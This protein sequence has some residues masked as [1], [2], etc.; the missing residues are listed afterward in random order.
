M[1][2]YEKQEIELLPESD[3]IQL[4]ESSQQ[5]IDSTAYK[6]DSSY[7][8][9]VRPLPL[10]D[11]EVRGY[12]RQDSIAAIPPAP[13]EDDDEPQD[14]ISLLVNEDGF[15]ANVK[16]RD[17]FS[18]LHLITGG[19]YDL[20]EHVFLQLKGPLQSVNYN[21]VDGFHGGYEI[22]LGNKANQKIN[23]EAGPLIRYNIA[24]E[25]FNYEGKLRLF[26]KGWNLQLNGG[27]QPR[28]FN[29]DFPLSP[30]SNSAYTLI[31]N[32]NYLKEYEQTFFKAEYN[33]KIAGGFGVD[34]G[35]EYAER[36]RCQPQSQ[37]S[38]KCCVIT[39]NFRT[40]NEMLRII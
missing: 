4:T 24:R 18:L 5:Y 19:R 17:K 26:G 2:E 13:G 3:T 15:A 28:Q 12:E 11:Y 37:L 7:W 38:D 40:S 27:K 22:E 34:L 29:Y 20:N 35:V 31:T 32:R 39:E 16:K 6:R 14:T 33:Q 10:T 9:V 30:W 21:T 1:K 23:W 8:E 36:K 25:S